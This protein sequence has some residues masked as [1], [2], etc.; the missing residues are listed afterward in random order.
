M[1]R[2][3]PGCTPKWSENKMLEF[4]ACERRPNGSLFRQLVASPGTGGLIVH[5]M[6]TRE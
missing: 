3:D 1:L 2:C 4:T 5:L 6:E